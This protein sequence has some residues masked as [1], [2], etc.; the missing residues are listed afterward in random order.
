MT[1]T[2]DFPLDE[3]VGAREDLLA[4]FRAFASDRELLGVEYER[5]PVVPESAAARG[6]DDQPVGVRDAVAALIGGAY[7]EE[8]LTAG[9]RR[10]VGDLGTITLEP[11]AQLE[12]SGAPVEDLHAVH[13]QMCA[14]RRVL[15][16]YTASLNIAWV[17]MGMQPVTALA[18]MRWAMKPRYDVMRPYLGSRGPQAHVMMQQ[19][20][21]IQTN[22]DYASEEDMSE[23][24][25][26]A[27]RLTPLL[28]ALFA[29]SPLREGRPAGALSARSLAWRETDPDR[30]GFIP[31]SL[32]RGFSF[33]DYVD[34]LL[35]VPMFFIVRRNAYIDM[36]HLSFRQYWEEGY[37]GS[38]ATMA[39]WEL[40]KSTIFPEVRLR[41]PLEVRAA[42]AQRPELA[43]S[44]A[45]V[46]CGLLY[47]PDARAAAVE[48][49]Q[50]WTVPELETLLV[51]AARFGPEA[52]IRGQTIR[53][54]MIEMLAI[55][56]QALEARD[57]R[58]ADGRTEARYLEPLQDLFVGSGRVPAEEVL[59][60]WEQ[61]GSQAPSQMVDDHRY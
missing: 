1:A 49:T 48:L 51:D 22:I 21:T 32:D 11:G 40:H 31:G 38:L 2:N 61:G 23:K 43:V 13:A 55:A 60:R 35:D 29:N 34:Y 26:A 28:M 37:Q 19:T 33:E 17:G 57:R 41:G 15:A 30:C 24:F 46:T 58:D 52:E 5:L 45:A 59:A 20:A 53:G 8:V 47:P 4:G 18:D 6:Y 44:V 7:R 3:P 16:E 39:D 56:G 36:T 42:D 14:E 9:D 25:V 50:G 12:F 54:R 10:L 27:S